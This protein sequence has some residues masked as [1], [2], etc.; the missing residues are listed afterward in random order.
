MVVHWPAGIPVDQR[1]TLRHQFT[2]VSDIAPTIYELLGV[3]APSSYRGIEQRPVTGHSFAGLVDDPAAPPTN[4]VQYFEMSG[5]RALVAGDWKAVCRHERGADF[6]TERW[7]LYDLASDPSECDDLATA[8][9]ERLAE[10]V[11]LWWQEAERHGV[12][13][14][15]ERTFELFGARFR[16][17]SPH[18]PSKRYVYRPPMSPMPGQAS[19]AIGGRSFDLTALVERGTSDEGV[20]FA[21]GTENAGLSVFVQGGRLLLDYNAFGDHAV[22]ESTLDV[23]VGRSEL[24]VRVRR[25]GGHGTASLAVDGAECG[26]VELPLFMRMMSSVGPSV[27]YD[28]GS[29]VSPRYR[30]PFPFTGTLERLEIQLLERADAPDVAARVEMSRQ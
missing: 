1:G 18:P 14:L 3:E 12:L 15:D 4:T 25:V 5:S 2:Y 8:E 16:A 13:P 10:L 24:T 7:E 29:A 19:A 28:H 17:R 23:P 11:A 9:P 20:L 22:V 21:T 26:T 30:A 6:D 27:G